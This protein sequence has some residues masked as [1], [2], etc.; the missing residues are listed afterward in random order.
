MKKGA[1]GKQILSAYGQSYRLMQ[2]GKR[3]DD[4]MRK[5]EEKVGGKIVHVSHPQDFSIKK[6]GKK[7]K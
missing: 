7:K 5:L 4:M 6:R 3:Y 2:E 1:T